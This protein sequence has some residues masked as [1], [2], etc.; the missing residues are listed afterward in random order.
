VEDHI[1]VNST[2]APQPKD[3][4]IDA[5]V[6]DAIQWLTTVPPESVRVSMD[7]G[8]V[9]L[10]GELLTIIK[11]HGLIAGVAGHELRTVTAVERAGLAPDFYLKTLHDTNF[12]SR[13]H[14]DQMNV[15]V[16]SASSLLLTVRIV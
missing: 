16:A 8:W 3:V 9:N 6:K 15:P 7:R 14:P 13:R 1:R 12:W 2:E 10:S 4:E 5:E 11:D